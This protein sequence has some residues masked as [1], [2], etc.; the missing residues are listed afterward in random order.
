MRPSLGFV[1]SPPLTAAV[2]ASFLGVKSASLD[3]VAY[4]LVLLTLAGYI[5]VLLFG[6]WFFR[7]CRHRAWLAPQS[8]AAAGAFSG[9][10]V[11]LVISPLSPGRTGWFNAFL[12]FASISVPLGAIGGLFFWWLSVRK[13]NG[14][15]RRQASQVTHLN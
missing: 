6:W 2:G 3:T 10:L 12:N 11:A 13:D 9:L 1:L 15:F 14:S 5:A 7:L 4:S 8:L